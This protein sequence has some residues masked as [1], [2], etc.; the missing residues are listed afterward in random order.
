MVASDTAHFQTATI[1]K[2]AHARDY[3]EAHVRHNILSDSDARP[4]YEWTAFDQD[5]WF[6]KT[7]GVV[8]ARK[9]GTG[10]FETSYEPLNML[11]GAKRNFPFDKNVNLL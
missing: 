1:M 8:L 6:A 9:E 5:S 11:L 10:E 2:K 3:C 4:Q 7:P